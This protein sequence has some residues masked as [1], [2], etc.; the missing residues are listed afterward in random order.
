MLSLSND[1]FPVHLTLFIIIS[2]CKVR[3]HQN[4]KRKKIDISAHVYGQN[5][6]TNAIDMLPLALIVCSSS[7]SL[8]KVGLILLGFRNRFHICLN[9]QVY[10][11][12]KILNHI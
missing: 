12:L 1:W 3:P 9:A 6:L 8:I 5:V 10:L 7:L 2:R 4:W 11:Y